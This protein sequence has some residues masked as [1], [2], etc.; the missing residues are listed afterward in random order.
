MPSIM[1]NKYM[2]VKR[3]A[4]KWQ[5]RAG[6]LVVWW[7]VATVAGEA[8]AQ[9]QNPKN[10]YVLGSGDV[11]R[12]TVYKNPDLTTEARV[13]EQGVITLPFLREVTVGGLTV[14][15]TEERIAGLLASRQLV[16]AP[17]V[18]IL[19]LQFRSQQVS[20]LG[21]VNRPGRYPIETTTRLSD[22]LAI[23]GGVTAI[24]ADY[25]YISKNRDGKIKRLAVDLQN[26]FEKGDPSLDVEIHHNDVIFVPRGPLF[27]IYGQVQRPGSFRLEKD[28]T[29]MQALSV[30]GGLTARGTER[31]LALSR[32]A[33]DGRLIAAEVELTDKLRPDDV[34]YVREGL[35]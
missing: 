10:D 26:L 2:R 9:G 7:L 19:V 3:E 12:F 30:G 16:V 31:G 35:F 25:L 17:Q 23:A 4:L 21:Q 27:Y 18:S 29:V 1:N 11:V 28:M 14:T 32:K 13:S 5:V 34:L 6:L 15:Q 20:V 33:N 24:G 22:I 8:L